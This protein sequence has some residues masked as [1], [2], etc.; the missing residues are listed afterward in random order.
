VTINIEGAIN[1][2]A[3]QITLSFDPALLAYQ[4][5]LPGPFLGSTGR[6]TSCFAPSVDAGSVTVACNSLGASPPGPSGSGLLHSITF[7]GLAGGVSPVVVAEALLSDVAANQKLPVNTF[8]ASIIV[9]GATLTPTTTPVPTATPTPTVTPT[10][11]ATPTVTPTASPTA[12]ATPTFTPTAT[13]TPTA[14]ATMTPAA[15]AATCPDMDGDGMILVSDILYSVRAYGQSDPLADLDGSGVVT[16][17]DI[18]GV[19]NLYGTTCT[20]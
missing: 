19:L 20:A 3:Y 18:L 16:V 17:S 4:S 11:T 10:P 13:V 14:T 8:D 7:R 2:G 5:H 6:A 9:D 12:T 1:L 15:G